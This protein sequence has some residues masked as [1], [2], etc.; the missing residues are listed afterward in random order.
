[1]LFNCIN[2]NA[3][4]LYLSGYVAYFNYSVLVLVYDVV[5]F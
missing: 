5:W 1:M 2:E 3:F 4:K